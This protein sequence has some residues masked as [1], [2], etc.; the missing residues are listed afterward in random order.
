M[1]KEKEHEREEKVAHAGSNWYKK[2]LQ[3]FLLKITSNEFLRSS[4][5]VQSFAV[6]MTD[7][8]TVALLE[9]RQETISFSY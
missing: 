8:G 6:S 1:H 5:K 2:Q 4:F 7:V 9:E 3:P